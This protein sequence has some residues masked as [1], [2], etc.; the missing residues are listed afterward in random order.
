[1]TGGEVVPWQGQNMPQALA[2]YYISTYWQGF[3]FAKKLWNYEIT[4]VEVQHKKPHLEARLPFNIFIATRH[5]K[6]IQNL[7]TVTF[8]FPYR[9]KRENESNNWMRG[10]LLRVIFIFTQTPR[11]FLH[12]PPFRR[13]SNSA[14]ANNS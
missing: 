7:Y 12:F 8:I 14:L 9:R 13:I 10:K 11:P 3:P 2:R 5:L 1:M 4:K 6:R